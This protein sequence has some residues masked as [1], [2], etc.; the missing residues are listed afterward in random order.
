VIENLAER[1]RQ[2]PPRK[3][4]VIKPSSLGDVIHALPILPSLRKLFP[5]SRI[6]WVVN[7]GFRSILDGHPDLDEVIAYDRGGSGIS[8]ASITAT[9]KLCGWL[10]DRRFDLAIDL[11]GLLRSGLMTAATRARIRVGMADAREGA[12]WFDTELVP[13]SRRET[14]AVD[15]V[16]QV[17]AALG[18]EDPRANF[19]IPIREE[20]RQWA[21]DALAEIPRPRLV[22]NLGARWLTKRWP[23][24]HFA[25]IGRRAAVDL[26]AGLIAVGSPEDRPLARTLQ[27]GLGAARCLDL[28]GNTTL[29]QLAAIAQECDLFLSNDT[30]PLH[31]AAAAGAAVVGIYTC[32][33]PRRTGPY[34][35]NATTVRSC[36]WCAPSFRKSCD[37]LECFDELTPGR[38]WPAVRNHLEPARQPALRSDRRDAP[39][40]PLAGLHLMRTT[41]APLL[42]SGE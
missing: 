32:T 21:R 13:S 16:L 42:K 3:I 15:R 1:L 30:G 29:R 26:G 27:Q 34:G 33:D 36:V 22:L 31:L 9:A 23:P 24:A 12:T 2:H 4:C 19:V 6:A 38:V 10:V 18:D 37:R 35:P 40:S 20:D 39:T 5:T 41:E 25:E 11:Q 8:R 7:Q 28:T 14:H 17:A